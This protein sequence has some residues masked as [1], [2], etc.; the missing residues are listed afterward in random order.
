MI[1]IIAAMDLEMETFAQE[2]QQVKEKT[3]CGRK[4][5]QGTL[6]GKEV[7]LV[8]SGIGKVNA[9]VTTQV[10]VDNFL[11][12]KIIHTGVAGGLAPELNPGD[13]VVASALIQ[14]DF[15]T[16]EFGDPKGLVAGF[17]SVDMLP[18]QELS[19]A[20]FESCQK[21]I[22]LDTEKWQVLRGKVATG[23]QF[24][25]SKEKSLEIRD[26]FDASACEMEGAAVAQA[27][28]INQIPFVVLRA[29]SDNASTGAKTDYQSFRE[30]AVQR[31]VKILREYLKC[32]L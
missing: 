26:T 31:T 25:A 7:V 18:D 28:L 27:A 30:K 17:D 10:L 16:S 15:D 1:G 6:F 19:Q 13:V 21:V 12:D 14:H 24:I 32:S 5:L 11:V 22:A 8:V 29:I 20:L 9:A 23:D 2:I 3:L 4:F